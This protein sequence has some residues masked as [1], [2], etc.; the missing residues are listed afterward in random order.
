MKK[1]CLLL[2]VIGLIIISMIG[3]TS[4][5]VANQ[6]EDK[7]LEEIKEN[8]KLVLGLD[9]SFPPMGYRDENGD[10]V[11]FDIDMAK[12]VAKRMGVELELKPI[13]WDGK[14]LS[15]NNK[16]IDVIW[17]GLTITEERLEKIGFSKPYLNNK[18]IIIVNND[19]SIDTKQDLAGKIVGVQLGS[20]GEDA[21]AADTETENSLK[22]VRRYSNYVD[23]LMDLK[24]ERVDA[25]VVD[26]VVGRYYISK[27]PGEY[28]IA[29]DNF[30][31]EQYGIG[32]RKGDISLINEVNRILDEMNDDGTTA[33]ISKKWF[34][35]DIVIK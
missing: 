24:A 14:V 27:K 21:L 29:K 4:Q 34:G 2:L 3:C 16:D 17:N 18:Q 8:G 22:E 5:E 19:S 13:D 32:F 35:K 20:S 9:D 12:E 6:E 1:F 7:S 15:L 30:G 31:E 25:V 28:K 23:A 33:E 11:G 26:E 10:I